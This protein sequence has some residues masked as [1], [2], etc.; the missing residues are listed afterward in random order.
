VDEISLN[1]DSNAAHTYNPPALPMGR[2]FFESST[3][4][5]GSCPHNPNAS[6]HQDVETAVALTTRWNHRTWSSAATVVKCVYRTVFAL[7]AVIIKA[8]RSSKSRKKRKNEKAGREIHG[9]F[10][11]L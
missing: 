6:I 5:V 3:T 2:Y 1:L 4:G 11:I 10:R 9:P 8:A 7:I